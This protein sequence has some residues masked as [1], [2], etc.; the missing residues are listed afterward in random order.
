MCLH[1]RQHTESN[2][3]SNKTQEMHTKGGC[4]QDAAGCLESCLGTL[5]DMEVNDLGD[6]GVSRGYVRLSV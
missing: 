2:V 6:S 1:S 5:H 4:I 3:K